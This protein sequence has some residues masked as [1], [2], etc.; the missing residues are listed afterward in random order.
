LLYNSEVS[1]VWII[2]ALG[3]SA[4]TVAVVLQLLD[5]DIHRFAGR[6][7][8]STLGLLLSL[9]GVLCL[10]AARGMSGDAG[11]TTLAHA[12]VLVMA[13]AAIWSLGHRDLWSRENSGK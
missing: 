2:P 11:R 3:V 10:L 6:L 12:V 4:L 7:T 1:L 13:G 9:E 8:A 5:V